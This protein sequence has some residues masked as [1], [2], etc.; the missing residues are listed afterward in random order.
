[1]GYDV[2]IADRLRARGLNVVEVAGWRTRGSSSFNPR[3]FLWHHTAGPRSGNSPS[4]NICIYGRSDLPGPL[5]NVFQARDN[6]IY[7]VAAGR[8][9]H[10]GSGGWRGLSGNSSVY[11]V[12]IENIGNNGEPWRLDQLDT[13]ARVAAALLGNP[14]ASCHHKEWTSRKPDMHTVSGDAMRQATRNVMGQPSVPAGPPVDLVAI[15]AAIAEARKHTLREGD[16]NDHVKWAQAG[17]NNLSGRGLA[18]DGAFGPATAAA[19]R[20]LQKFFG[21]PETG[22]VDA[23]VWGILFDLKP[24]APAPAPVGEA[25]AFLR[26]VA[27]AAKSKPTLRQ[28]AS[29]E[30]VKDLQNHLTANG[31]T[32]V[33]DGR[34]GPATSNAVKAYQ[35]SR[36]LTVD[37]IAGY[38]TWVA[39]I[40]DAFKRYGR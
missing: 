36:R 16:N 38:D 8:A 30:A 28:G 2:G 15:A 34:F 39:L 14:D 26:M 31:H 4:L 10:A 20:D 13:A 27:D 22:V 24:A 6:T 40:V 35:R 37:G 23:A 18:V 33:I 29:G 9:N 12:E 32:V 7:V 19:V 21:L 17:I 3:G 11:G 25:E 1:M 5:C